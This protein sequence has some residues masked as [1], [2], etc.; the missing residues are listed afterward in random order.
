[1]NEVRKK[2]LDE[3]YRLIS[4]QGFN[5]TSTNQICK[6][7]N[8]TKPSLYYY[9]KNKEEILLELLEENEN[10]LFNVFSETIVFKSKN[11][12][13]NYFFEDVLNQ[14]ISKLDDINY[15][16]FTKEIEM[17]ATRND[18]IKM[19]VD[20]YYDKRY[21]NLLEIINQGIKLKIFKNNDASDITNLIVVFLIGLDSSIVYGNEL[22][23][24]KTWTLFFKSLINN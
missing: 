7:I 10:Y 1:M 19:K 4:L 3:T 21:T 6:N 12:Y 2:I 5:K 16:N 15:L 11:E 20:T 22:D 14:L 18:S 8:I 24:K 9:F 23:V 17:L 13:K